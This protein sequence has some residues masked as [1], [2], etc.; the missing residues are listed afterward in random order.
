MSYGVYGSGLIGIIL[1][2]TGSVS[3]RGQKEIHYE[4]EIPDDALDI[5]E[6]RYAK[7]EISKEE[8]DDM[9]KDLS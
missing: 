5:L 6:K 8:F 9:K 2:I 4:R 3:S 1:L 7:G